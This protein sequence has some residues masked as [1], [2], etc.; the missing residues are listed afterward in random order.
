MKEK[1]VLKMELKKK[2][3]DLDRS[4]FERDLR[5]QKI[6]TATLVEEL[7][8]TKALCTELKEKE[9]RTKS[10]A[11]TLQAENIRLKGE[12]LNS[13]LKPLAP[14]ATQ[15]IRWQN[16]SHIGHKEDQGSWTSWEQIM[17]RTCSAFPT[18]PPRSFPVQSGAK[19]CCIC[20]Y[21]YSTTHPTV[22]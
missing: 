8:K 4:D 12:L 5:E 19:S 1:A 13:Q 20:C 18:F 2:E 21:S 15:P 7:A 16:Q 3:T 6:M 17:N 9:R 22:Y 10:E 11:H 14:I